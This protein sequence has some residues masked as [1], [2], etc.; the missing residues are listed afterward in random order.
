[1]RREELQRR[2]VVDIQEKK[3]S[4]EPI[5][6]NLGASISGL[7]LETSLSH[8]T[9]DRILSLLRDRQI[10]YFADQDIRPKDL[11]AIARLFGKPEVHPIWPGLPGCPEVARI[12]KLPGEEDPLGN[13]PRTVTSFFEAPSKFVLIYCDEDEIVSDYL[14]TSLTAAYDGLSSHMQDFLSGLTATHSPRGEFG[15]GNRKTHYFQG[16]ISSPLI[17]SDAIFEHKEHP[18]VHVHPETGKKSLFLNETFTRN[19][20]GLKDEESA[21]LLRFLFAHCARPEFGCRIPIRPKSLVLFDNR[22]TT[23]TTTGA[24]LN[25]SRL[26]YFAAVANDEKITSSRDIPAPPGLLI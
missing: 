21:H 12:S 10:L 1:M 7:K 19:I 6:A 8:Q 25:Q 11:L 22:F 2:Q 17:Y 3:L 4:A 15:P 13:K 5:G 9:F 18:L 14:F 16:Q 20:V 23:Q 24:P 26:L